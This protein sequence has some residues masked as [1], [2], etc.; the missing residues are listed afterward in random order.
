MLGKPA[1]GEILHAGQE[2]DNAV[3]TFAVKVVKKKNS[4]SFTV[5]VLAYFVA[6]AH[7]GKNY[8]KHLCAGME[9][10]CRLVFSCSSR[11]KINRLKELL[12]S[13]IRR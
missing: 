6:I 13:K 9:I 2:L 11:V 5:R 12:E 7:G 10:P 8:G 3:D 4:R 1:I